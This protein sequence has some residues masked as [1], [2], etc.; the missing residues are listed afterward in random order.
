M[1]P[2]IPVN[3]INK[4]IEPTCFEKSNEDLGRRKS[5]QEKKL[6]R[7]VMATD[8]ICRTPLSLSLV[9]SSSLTAKETPTLIGQSVSMRTETAMLD[10]PMEKGMS[11]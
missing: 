7:V 9:T 5:Q 6:A 10:T 1:Q 2:P 11:V 4:L 8:L 3:S